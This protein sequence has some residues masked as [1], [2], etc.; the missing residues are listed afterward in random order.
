MVVGGG[1]AVDGRWWWQERRAKENWG[2]KCPAGAPAQMAAISGTL[3]D[4][5]RRSNGLD[6]RPPCN[7]VKTDGHC[8]LDDPGD[9]PLCLLV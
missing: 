4:A 1:R 2:K 6:C 5:N 7:D 9:W 8:E 3:R